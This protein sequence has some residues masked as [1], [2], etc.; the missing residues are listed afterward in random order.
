ME[1]AQNHAENLANLDFMQNFLFEEFGE[2]VFSRWSSQGK[3]NITPEEVIDTWYKESKKFN[4][5]F[6]PQ[7]L[8]SG[9]FSNTNSSCSPVKS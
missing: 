3:V 5:D 9:S 7:K 8:T 4:Y 2:N 6:E 1:K